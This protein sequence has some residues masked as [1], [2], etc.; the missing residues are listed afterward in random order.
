[1]NFHEYASLPENNLERE[2]LFCCL[3]VFVPETTA[4]DDSLC[5][6][7]E[8]ETIYA[9]RRADDYHFMISTEIILVVI[10][11]KSFHT[12]ASINLL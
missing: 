8:A 3:A 9:H 6:I 10:N 12:F 4:T 1:M 7:T 11:N 5:M 2:Q